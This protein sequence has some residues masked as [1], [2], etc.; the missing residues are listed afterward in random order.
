VDGYLVVRQA[1]AH[2]WAE[3]WLGDNGWTRID[4]TAA[5]VPIRIESGI[6]AAAPNGL[7]LPLLMRTDLDWLKSLRNEWDALS[8][9][10]NQWVLGFN[11]DRQREMLTWLGVRQP[12]WETMIM[13]L[14]WSVGGM[15]LLIAFWLLR[16]LRRVDPVQRAWLRF[17]DKL[18]YAG[19]PRAGAEGPLDYAGRVSARLPQRA[20]AVGAIAQLYVDLRYGEQGD[21]DS[22]AR[23]KRLVREFSP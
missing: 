1:D 8:N 18:G 23:L 19:L 3:V 6:N 12:D 22:R 4:P 9:Q 10:W 15:L 16:G 7:S 13:M 2:A 14:F 11:P 17:C 21:S 5:A 20:A